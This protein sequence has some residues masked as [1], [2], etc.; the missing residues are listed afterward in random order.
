MKRQTR[1]RKQRR[2]LPLAAAV[3]ALIVVIGAWLISWW[4]VPIAA[5][6]ATVAW[7]DRFDVVRDVMWGAV[8]GWVV[9]LLI[10]SLHGRT[11]ALARAAGGAV[12]LPWGLLIPATLLFAAGLAWATATLARGACLL[13]AERIA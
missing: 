8:L 6:I 3:T 10:D 1:S 11:W 7:W 4:I 13:I 12:F 2:S 9:L 5:L